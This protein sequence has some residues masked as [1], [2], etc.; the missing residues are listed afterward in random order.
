MVSEWLLAVVPVALLA[1]AA[2]RHEHRDPPHL[3]PKA[4]KKIRSFEKTATR[5]RALTR[6]R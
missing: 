1:V 2:T 6:K 4:E 5:M 3:D